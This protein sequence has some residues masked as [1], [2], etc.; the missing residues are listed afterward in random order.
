MAAVDLRQ[1][2][3]SRLARL[4]TGDVL[5][6]RL[7]HGTRNRGMD[8]PPALHRL[9]SRP[10]PALREHRQLGEERKGPIMDMLAAVLAFALT[11]YSAYVVLFPERFN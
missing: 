2:R 7:Y 6:E 5:G 8:R 9:H 10:L 3:P 4:A 1:R 11:I